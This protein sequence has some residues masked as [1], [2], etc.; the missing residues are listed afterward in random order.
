VLDSDTGHFA[1]ADHAAEVAGLTREFLRKH[2][3]SK[4]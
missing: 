3:S 1:L 4:K 2:V